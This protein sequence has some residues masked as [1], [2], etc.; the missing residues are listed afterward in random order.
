MALFRQKAVMP[1][2]QEALPG[3]EAALKVPETHDVN[4]KPIMA[5]FPRIGTNGFLR[6]VIRTTSES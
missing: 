5:L 3:R 1:D 2:P 6:R 4:G